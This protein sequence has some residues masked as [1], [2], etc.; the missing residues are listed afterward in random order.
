MWKQILKTGLLA[1]TLDIVAACTQAYV[2]RGTTPE[3]VLKFIASGVLGSTAMKGGAEVALL[4]LLFHLVIAFSCTIV[5]FLVYPKLKLLHKNIAL[6]SLLIAVIAWAVTTL[7]VIPLSKINPA[8]F[9]L[10]RAVIAILIL[11][12]CIGLPVAIGAKFF[13]SK[14]V[15]A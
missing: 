3:T 4:G 1:G 2:M 11:Y 8:P 9:Q 15:T 7:I 14:T 6:N 13:Y 12:V 5:F 10:Q